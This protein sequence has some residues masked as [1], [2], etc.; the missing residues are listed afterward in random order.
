MFYVN[1]H[2]VGSIRTNCY[3]VTDRAT[4]KSVIIDPG[5]NSNGLYRNI[6]K[7]GFDNIKYIL[8]THGHF[9]HIM[10]AD[11]YRKI[12]GAKIVINK[13]EADFTK[14]KDL[15]LS[16]LFTD[17]GMEPFE[18]DVFLGDGDTIEIGETKIKMLHTPGHTKGG[19]CYIIGDCIFSGDTLMRETVGR[20]DLI[21]GDYNDIIAS[22]RKLAD[23]RENYKVYP[24]HGESTTLDYERENNPYLGKANYDDIY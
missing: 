4:K 18:A 15:N 8:L 17:Y 9:D 14:N 2:K 20:T 10:R 19:A 21:T 13:N 6:K 12:T 23:I 11:E 24:G 3:I 7:I 5:D 22:V 1:Q 16:Y